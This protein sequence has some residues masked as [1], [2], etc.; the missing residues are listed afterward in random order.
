MKLFSMCQKLSI[1]DT[2]LYREVKE[3]DFPYLAEHFDNPDNY[4]H[5]LKLSDLEQEDVRTTL[6]RSD[7]KAAMIKCLSLWYRH[8]HDSLPTFRDLIVIL[9]GLRKESTAFK[10][11]KYLRSQCRLSEN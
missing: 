4:Y 8:H 2:L 3:F 11:A 5:V 10:I 7:A 1:D 9:L 6:V